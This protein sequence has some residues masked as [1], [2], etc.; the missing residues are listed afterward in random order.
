MRKILCNSILLVCAV[1]AVAILI[2]LAEISLITPPVGLNVYV[3]RSASPVP[4]RLEEVFAGVTPFLILDLFTLG[5]LTVSSSPFS[6]ALN[7]QG[8]NR[9]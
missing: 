9:G 3:V 5:L 1:T 8:S 7:Q 4:F 6:L 2:E